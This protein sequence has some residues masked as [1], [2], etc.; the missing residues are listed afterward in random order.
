MQ[1]ELKKRLKA[2][3]MAFYAEPPASLFAANAAAG[4]LPGW[5]FTAA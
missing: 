2:A 4:F 5:D 3:P 1:A